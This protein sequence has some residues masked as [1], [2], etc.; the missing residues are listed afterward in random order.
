MDKII[1]KCNKCD[2]EGPHVGIQLNLDALGFETGDKKWC[3]Q[4]LIN[5]WDKYLGSLAP[6]GVFFGRDTAYTLI[7]VHP[8]IQINKYDS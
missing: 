6:T 5:S 1:Y 3:L 4:C 7:Q 2:Y 8:T